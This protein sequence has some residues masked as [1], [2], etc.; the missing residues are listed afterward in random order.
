MLIPYP[1]SFP[2]AVYM[3]LPK[4][5]HVFQFSHMAWIHNF[6]KGVPLDLSVKSLYEFK[7]EKIAQQH[8][9][10]VFLVLVSG[11]IAKAVSVHQGYNEAIPFLYLRSPFCQPVEGYREYDELEK[12]FISLRVYSTITVYS[13][14]S[15]EKSGCRGMNQVESCLLVLPKLMHVNEIPKFQQQMRGCLWK[16]LKES[17][18]IC[19]STVYREGSM[20]LRDVDKSTWN[21]YDN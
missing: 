6:C 8:M 14:E 20:K 5:H 7:S 16:S 9:R 2:C 12:D 13:S 18:W 17:L 4:N 19:G 21:F 1:M 10:Q 15:K 3:K 11:D